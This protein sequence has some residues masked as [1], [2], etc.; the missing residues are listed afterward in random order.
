M[1]NKLSD[2]FSSLERSTPG[3]EWAA[4]YLSGYGDEFGG[5]REI[6]T[7]IDGEAARRG[8]AQDNEQLYPC[9]TELENI[10]N[11]PENQPVILDAIVSAG[12]AL[13]C[14]GQGSCSGL[15]LVVV[16]KRPDADCITVPGDELLKGLYARVSQWSFDVP[17]GFRGLMIRYENLEDSR[18][19]E[20][21]IA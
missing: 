2:I 8:A 7:C 14:V 6:E 13:K 1:S 16:K 20:S 15:L 21:A 12:H 19:A 4:F 18:E 3:L 5:F 9:G 10:V 11:S 17:A